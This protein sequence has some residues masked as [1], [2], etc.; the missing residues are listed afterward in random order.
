LSSGALAALATQAPVL[1]KNDRDISRTMLR[2]IR[3]DLERYYYDPTFHGI[4]LNARFAEAE[5]RIDKA[6]N[7]SEATAILTDIVMQLDDSHTMFYPPRRSASVDY[8]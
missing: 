8:G 2:Q 5:T 7:A 4:D 6:A 3:E 1:S